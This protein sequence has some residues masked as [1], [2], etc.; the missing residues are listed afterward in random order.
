MDQPQSLSVI[1]APVRSASRIFAAVDI[2]RD[3]LNVAPDLQFCA[4]GTV[5]DDVKV[6][7]R[8]RPISDAHHLLGEALRFRQ[9]RVLHR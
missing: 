2:D 9:L 1:G 5:V 7:E 4:S 6:V 3:A 8:G